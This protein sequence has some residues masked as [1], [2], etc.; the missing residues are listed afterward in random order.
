MSLYG[1]G[2]ATSP[3]LDALAQESIVFDNALA[4]ASATAWSHRSL[5]QSRL[6]SLAGPET[7]T[8]AEVLQAHG[9][10]TLGLT[11]GGQMSRSLGFGRGFERYDELGEGLAQS[12][13]QLEVWLRAEARAPWYVFLHTYDVHLPYA[14]PPPHDTA[15]FPEYKG[16]ITPERTVEVCR[17]IRRLFEHADFEGEVTLTAADREKMTALYDGGIRHTDALVG[18][19]LKLLRAQ[20]RLEDTVLVILSDHGEEFW[21][22]GSVLHGHSLYQEL[23]HVPLIVRLPGARHG[24]RRVPATV[25]LLDVAPTI[26]ELAGLPVPESFQGRS[27]VGALE[28]EAGE[29]RK[30]TSEMGTLKTRIERPWKLILDTQ[31][32]QPMLFDLEEDPGEHSDLASRRPERVVAL[33]EALRRS[34]PDELREVPILPPGDLPPELREQLRA[35]GYVVE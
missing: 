7:P 19:L 23:L 15:F 8:F 20:G 11:D 21:E 22:H 2:R 31:E 14:P 1:Y 18:R 30:V 5:F 10:Q 26:L 33:T 3:H 28:G 4:Q 25:R 24:G 35:L 32:P 29:E 9:Y 12:L 17:K 16:P 6:P 34:L 27:L 13:P